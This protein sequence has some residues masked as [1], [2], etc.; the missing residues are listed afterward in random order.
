M[1]KK[2]VSFLCYS[3]LFFFGSSIVYAQTVNVTSLSAQDFLVNIANQVPQLMKMATALA[4]VIG[5]YLIIYGILKLKH[6]GEQRTM[7]SSEHGLAG[8]LIM[9]TIGAVLL[10]LP[11]SVQVGMST[12]WSAPNPYGY[13]Q[14]TDQWGE[15]LSVCFSII[16]FVGVLAFI[17]GMVI[18]SHLGSSHGS[19]GSLSR[20]LTHIIGG[21]LCINIY[22][23]VHTILN[24]LG[25][26][27][28]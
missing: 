8:P 27:F 24:T 26:Q 20:G 22:M 12:F 17:K 16:Q 28:T 4:Y 11:T 7:M 23:T 21:I 5:M 13:V 6:F 9:M 15:F 19:Q 18:L 25:V 1:L 3:T 14:Q 2:Y 10:Y